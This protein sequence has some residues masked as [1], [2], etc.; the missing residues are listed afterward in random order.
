MSKM[1]PG[2]F[3]GHAPITLQSAFHD[4][5]EALEEWG[6]GSEEPRVPVDGLSVPISH[7]FV[8]MNTCTDLMPLRTRGVLEAII[9]RDVVRATGGTLYADAAKLAMALCV[10][11]LGYAAPRRPPAP[12]RVQAQQACVEV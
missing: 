12:T 7:V 6:E 10:K 5:L 11:R 3:E 8:A 9:D 4:A 1:L 2:L